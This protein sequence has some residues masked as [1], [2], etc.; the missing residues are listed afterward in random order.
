MKGI[1][2]K[3]YCKDSNI[4]ECYIGSTNDLQ[5]RKYNHKNNCNNNNSP[6][7]NFKVYKFIK[8]NGGWD[9]WDFE[10]LEETNEDLKQ[11]EK[12]YILT[13]KPELNSRIEARTKKEYYE[14]NKEKILEYKKKYR[15]NNKEKIQ[16]FCKLKFK[17]ECGG[18]YYYNNKTN[19]EKTKKHQK[20]IS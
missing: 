18:K 11:L 13:I 12:Q 6:S 4:T 2:Y 8:N 1:V 10:I 3:I 20:F 16:K 17:C 9:N 5:T 19:H 14:D 15:E 7:Y